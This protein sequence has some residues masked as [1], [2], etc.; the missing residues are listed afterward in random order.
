MSVTQ[1]HYIEHL[2]CVHASMD[3]LACK[4]GKHALPQSLLNLLARPYNL[5]LIELRQFFFLG[6]MHTNG[7]QS[8]IAAAVL[9]YFCLFTLS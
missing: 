8:S 4:L 5:L 6:Y 7:M 2:T 1:S 9:F 3:M